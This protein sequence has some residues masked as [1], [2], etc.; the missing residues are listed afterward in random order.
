MGR[1]TRATRSG[2]LGV[3]ARASH[4]GAVS[5]DKEK[6]PRPQQRLFSGS[7]HAR[8][9]SLLATPVTKKTSGESSRHSQDQLRDGHGLQAASIEGWR[10]TSGAEFQGNGVGR[11]SQESSSDLSTTNRPYNKTSHPN[12]QNINRRSMP[13]VT[14]GA[15][16]W[17][18]QGQK[19]AEG[20]KEGLWSLFEDIRQA[21][22]GE[23]GISGPNP[24]VNED[25]MSTSAGIS[26]ERRPAD[27]DHTQE[28]ATTPKQ[29]FWSQFGVDTPG[30]PT[31]VDG[32][33]RTNVVRVPKKV[34][35]RDT[36]AQT[37]T[38]TA[39]QPAATS[40]RTLRGS[41]RPR[42]AVMATVTDLLV[43]LGS[44]DPAPSVIDEEEV[45]AE[46]E[47]EAWESPVPIKGGRGFNHDKRQGG[48]DGEGRTVALSSG[49]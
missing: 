43:D 37:T 30:K 3:G 20:L 33:P 6:K 26:Q 22:V 41:T 28:A 14:P 24:A 18:R 47:W 36:T 19:V 45:E 32:R 38:S 15:E 2:S 31:T 8:T 34:P 21:T 44:D 23:E 17:V 48:I 7:R 10:F 16:I 42:A 5:H 39:R 25:T 1:P 4:V 11:S 49:S 27:R 9:L 40:A 46:G 13:P 35:L 29:S 12:N